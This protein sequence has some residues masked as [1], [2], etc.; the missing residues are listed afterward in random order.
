MSS[1]TVSGMVV[2]ESQSS[3][4][5]TAA[6][7][8]SLLKDK[9]IL[10]FAHVDFSADA[11]HVGLSLKP[12]R[13]LIFGNPKAGTPLLAQKPTVGLDLP[14]KALI[15]EDEAGKV[16][17]GYNDPKYLTERH[18]VAATLQQN[19]TAVIPLLERSL[20]A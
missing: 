7:L 15:W 5:D 3:V 8:E 13:L 12:E 11:A 9:G 4:A 18:G 10:V 16:W 20:H 1:G 2:L 17:L 14:L 6:R 19:L